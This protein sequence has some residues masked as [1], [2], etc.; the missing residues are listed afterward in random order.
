MAARRT[1]QVRDDSGQYT[2]NERCDLC[3]RNLGQL[4]DGHWTF[5]GHG[6]FIC[7]P[8]AAEPENN[9]ERGHEMFAAYRGR[10]QG[11]KRLVSR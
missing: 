1:D 7:L 10:G 9:A 3:G 2:T 4:D 8:C 5:G 6:E 11:H